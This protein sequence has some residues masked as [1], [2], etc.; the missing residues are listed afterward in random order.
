MQYHEVNLDMPFFM[1][2]NSLRTALVYDANANANFFGIGTTKESV[3]QGFID[4][5]NPAEAKTSAVVGNEKIYDKYSDFYKDFLDTKYT[6]YNSYSGKVEEMSLRKY[7]IYT[8]KKP[9][10][11]LNMYYN[12]TDW[13]QAYGRC[14]VH[15]C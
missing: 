7:F 8:R 11:W 15:V 5:R 10:Y 14:A 1:V 2:P 4:V 13:C 6:D 3:L 9:T 12:V